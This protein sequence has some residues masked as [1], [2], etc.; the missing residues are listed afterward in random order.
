[1]TRILN[2]ERTRN[3]LVKQL[4]QLHQEQTKHHKQEQYLKSDY[5]KKIAWRLKHIKQ[6][7]Q[8]T[9]EKVDSIKKN[10]VLHGET[11]KKISREEAQP[12]L[13][14]SNLGALQ[15]RPT[16]ALFILTV[17][18]LSCTMLAITVFLRRSRLDSSVGYTVSL[19]G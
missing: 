3:L 9:S 6:M 18:A 17:C 2:S 14:R 11:L 4:Q 8:A 10:I 7:Q 5:P 15:N 19:L 16:F 12:D 13:G 1:M